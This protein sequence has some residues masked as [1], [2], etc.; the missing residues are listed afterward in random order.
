MRVPQTLHKIN[1]A[2]H[3][4]SAHKKEGQ[5]FI[6]LMGVGDDGM[7]FT[8]SGRKLFRLPMRLAA[9]VQRVQHWVAKWSWKSAPKVK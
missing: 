9:L 5:M 4:S 1:R 6:G 3:Y 2:E 7:L 8:P